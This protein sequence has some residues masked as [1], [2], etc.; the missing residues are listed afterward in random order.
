MLK[1]EHFFVVA[2]PSD[3]IADLIPVFEMIEKEQSNPQFFI[4]DFG[5]SQG[6]LEE[7][8]LTV[9]KD[10]KNGALESYKYFYF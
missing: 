3:R 4:K 9:T 5:V 1:Q 7:V 10:E 6:T 2:Y 8:F